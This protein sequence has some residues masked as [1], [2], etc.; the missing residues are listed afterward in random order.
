MGWLYQHKPYGMSASEFLR[1][2]FSN[3]NFEVL[4]VAVVKFREAY[5]AL[6][7]KKT[8]EVFCVICLLDYRPHD[9]YNFG[10]KDMDETMHP[11]AYNCPERILKQLTPTDNENA[12]QWRAICWERIQRRSKKV[13]NGDI[14]KF[15]YPLSFTDGTVEDTFRVL[16]DGRAVRFESAR[17]AYSPVF[18]IKGWRDMDFEIIKKE[19]IM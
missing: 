9:Y 5:I 18:R 15:K 14:I 11:Y 2:E 10:Y 16:K 7:H 12:N 4:D 13:N 8:N 17:K 3:E 1:N 19:E 6:R